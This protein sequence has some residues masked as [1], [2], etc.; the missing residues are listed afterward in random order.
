MHRIVPGAKP[1]NNCDV[2]TIFTAP[3]LQR[4]SRRLTTRHQKPVRT[5]KGVCELARRRMA[6]PKAPPPCWCWV[7]APGGSLTPVRLVLMLRR[8]FADDWSS[9]APVE[10]RQGQV[11][12]IPLECVFNQL[13]RL[14]KHWQRA[15]FPVHLKRLL[16]LLRPGNGLGAF[17][18][19]PAGSRHAPSSS[20]TERRASNRPLRSLSPRIGDLRPSRTFLNLKRD[21]DVEI[22]RLAGV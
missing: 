9:P 20:S 7:R 3:C 11:R 6:P 16:F 14:L 1:I 21:W 19:H 5:R 13:W 12:E 2:S 18:R 10:G 4:M 8:S 17:Q 15:T 22:L